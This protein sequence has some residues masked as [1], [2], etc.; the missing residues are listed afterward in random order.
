MC[1]LILYKFYVL[2]DL[3]VG[4]SNPFGT[5][6]RAADPFGMDTFSTPGKPA[7]VG[8]KTAFGVF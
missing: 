7:Q 6:V 2:R 1:C 4:F 3:K 8:I 5:P